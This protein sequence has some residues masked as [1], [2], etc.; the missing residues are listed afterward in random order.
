MNTETKLILTVFLEHNDKPHEVIIGMIERE[1][2]LKFV[3]TVG[4]VFSE[5]VKKI[6]EQEEEYEICAK[7][8]DA[9]ERCIIY[10]GFEKI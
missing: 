6:F 10:E 9:I 5:R 1:L 8:R 7:I 2:Y 3:S 4:V